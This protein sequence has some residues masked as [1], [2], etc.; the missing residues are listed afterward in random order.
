MSMIA[1]KIVRFNGAYLK[2]KRIE[3][4]YSIN[5]L[6]KILGVSRETI[7]SIE[8]NRSQPSLSLSM[9]ICYFFGTDIDNFIILESNKPM[10]IE[11]K[12]PLVGMKVQELSTG[13]KAIVTG[14]YLEDDE[15]W[16]TSGNDIGVFKISHF[17]SFFQEVK[18]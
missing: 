1:E 18:S 6:A 11:N 17:W 7:R 10:A 3:G 9:K 4:D 15:V 13:R 8:N 12:T 2:A 5:A 14:V 16:M